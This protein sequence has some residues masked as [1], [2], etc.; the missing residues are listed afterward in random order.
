MARVAAALL[1]A[2]F[3]F[4]RMALLAPFRRQ[5]REIRNAV[6]RATSGEQLPIIDTVERL[7]G[8]S[9]DVAMVSLASSD[10]DHLTS[11]A[12]FYFSDNR[13]NV[14]LSRAKTKVVLFGSP[15]V[16]HALPRSLNAA[17]AVTRLG[18]VLRAA[19]VLAPPV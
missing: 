14:A 7:Q 11:I 15:L 3:S 1:G 2:G 8:Q 17:L 12:D 19:H 18:K 4:E 13:W 6:L 9:V 16:L 5:V 10:P